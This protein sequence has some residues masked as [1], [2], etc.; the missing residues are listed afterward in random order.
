M[1][2]LGP[3]DEKHSGITIREKVKY[4]NSNLNHRQNDF[5]L[6]QNLINSVTVFILVVL[7]FFMSTMPS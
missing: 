5:D 1:T 2:E 4:P 7:V 3:E 6:K